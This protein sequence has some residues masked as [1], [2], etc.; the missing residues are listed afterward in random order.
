MFV[1]S[2]Q[3]QNMACR[4]CALCV[5]FF[6][7]CTATTPHVT[8]QRAAALI[9]DLCIDRSS[10][11]YQSS[12]VQLRATQVNAAEQTHQTLTDLWNGMDV[13]EQ[14]M[15]QLES[16]GQRAGLPPWMT[17]V[18]LKLLKARL[19]WSKAS[20]AKYVQILG[21]FDTGTNLL[22]KMIMLNFPSLRTRSDSPEGGSR[23]P[24]IWK[25]SDVGA[26]D[27]VSAVKEGLRSTESMSDVV[28]IAMV[29][30][31]ISNMVSLKKAPYNVEPCMTRNYTEMHESCVGYVGDTHAFPLRVKFFRSTMDVYNSYLRQYKKLKELNEFREVLIVSYEDLLLD[32][33]LVMQQIAEAT[34]QKLPAD[35]NVLSLASKNHGSPVSRQQALDRLRNR[36]Y[37]NEFA[38]NTA[39]LALL[40]RDL[41]KGL[42]KDMV[43]GSL[44]E[45]AYQVRYTQDCDDL[46]ALRH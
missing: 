23:N 14:Q 43:E 13:S 28:A 32:P 17:T 16:T 11:G 37:L 33:N 27:I 4:F 36:S 5:T 9:D 3:L 39:G 18:G 40:C 38:N 44:R 26:E 12:F 8:D 22:E 45:K 29:R 2:G 15:T 1:V 20:P 19:P 30:S 21:L 41:D 24:F 25:H 7:S 10:A 35:V 31:P 42:I 34:G 6:F 46:E